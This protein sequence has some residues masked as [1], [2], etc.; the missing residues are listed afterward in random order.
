MGWGG[1]GGGVIGV[2]RI[3]SHYKVGSMHTLGEVPTGTSSEDLFL[4]SLKGP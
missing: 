4:G 2:Y 3:V 1:G